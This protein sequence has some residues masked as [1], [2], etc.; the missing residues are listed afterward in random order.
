MAELPTAESPEGFN[1][2]RA[3][4]NASYREQSWQQAELD[5]IWH[6][7]WVFAATVDVVA[8]PGDQYPVMVGHQPVLLVRSQDGALTALSNLC[9][10]RGTLLVDE[11]ANAKRIQCPYHAWTYT[12]SGELLSV[13]FSPKGEV[14]KQAHCLPSYRVEEWHGLIF[15]SLNTEVEPLAERF[16]A[17]DTVLEAAGDLPDL[18]SLHAW[19]DGSRIEEWQCNWKLAIVNAMESYHLFQVHP[20]TLEP[21]T[22]TRDSYYI[23]GSAR[24]TVT[25]SPVVDGS[26][27]LVI[28]L[29]PAFVGVLS[30]DGFI[31]LS[32]EPLA[33]DRCRIVPGGAFPSKP[34]SRDA[35]R[36]SKWLAQ[37]AAE[38]YTAALPDFL[39]ED[40]AICERGQIGAT[41]DYEPGPLLEV[42]RIVQD[43]G[44]YLAWKLHG[45]EPPAV[46]TAA[47]HQARD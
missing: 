14:D 23:A 11:A 27:S 45:V 42:E 29:P 12:D 46:H 35:G 25:A 38:A 47:A 30:P 1:P 43:F 22:P 17:V 4:P 13:P 26:R 24:A 33:V 21:I 18:D 5:R 6:N 34:P 7:D 20:N 41:G 10:H 15:V 19:I 9:A 37:T 28:S 39:P 44:H 2:L 8:E 16:A 40:K 32:V 3:L 31:W 36:F